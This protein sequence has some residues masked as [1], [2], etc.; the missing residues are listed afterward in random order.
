M[1]EFEE[2]KRVLLLIQRRRFKGGRL[3]RPSINGGEV[4]DGIEE[5]HI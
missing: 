5:A 1:E 3:V 4:R 2:L